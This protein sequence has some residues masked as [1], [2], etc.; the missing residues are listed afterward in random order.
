MSP[1]WIGSELAP[2][3]VIRRFD[4]FAEFNRVTNVQKGVPDDLAKGQALWQ[5]K[6]VAS[7][8]YGGAHSHAARPPAEQG[9]TEHLEH[10]EPKSEFPELS[11]QPQ[12]DKMFDREIV[13]RMGTDFYHHV[14][15]PAIEE[16]FREGKS[17]EEIRDTLRA[18]WKPSEA[19]QRRAA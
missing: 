2:K 17:Y 19:R 5:A 9:V 13:A 1:S 8:R 10:K 18:Q 16:A 11:G 6:L 15:S 7:R 4:V 3:R 14:F 12:T